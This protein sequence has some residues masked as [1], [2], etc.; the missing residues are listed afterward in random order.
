MLRKHTPNQDSER[1]SNS[2]RFG[3][4]IIGWFDHGLLLRDTRDYH[5]VCFQ[6]LFLQQKK[7]RVSQ[8][9][10]F[11]FLTIWGFMLNF[12]PKTN[13]YYIKIHYSLSF[14]FLVKYINY[15]KYASILYIY[16]FYSFVFKI[17][18]LKK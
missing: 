8:T 1:K 16:I 4:A 17:F 3:L 2:D 13:L 5:P 15:L 18:F 7:T 11:F 12:R 14:P 9:F 6:T 10:F